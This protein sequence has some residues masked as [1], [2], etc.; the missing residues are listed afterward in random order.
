MPIIIEMCMPRVRMYSVYSCA[1]GLHENRTGNDENNAMS[2]HFK[3]D[4][5][6]YLE[7]CC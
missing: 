6:V 2:V 5:I 3:Y 7:N 1:F 4:I